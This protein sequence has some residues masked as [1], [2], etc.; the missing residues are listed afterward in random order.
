[1]KFDGVLQN[2]A[3]CNAALLTLSFGEQFN[4][5]NLAHRTPN[6]CRNQTRTGRSGATL[7]RDEAIEHVGH[8]TSFEQINIGKIRERATAADRFAPLP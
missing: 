5:I 2:R 6:C 4:K 8:V 3:R 7:S 1:M